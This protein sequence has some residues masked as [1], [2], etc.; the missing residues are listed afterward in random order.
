[1]YNRLT[2]MGPTDT[3]GYALNCMKVSV[4][5]ECCFRVLDSDWK[6][7]VLKKN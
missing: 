7:T 1:M 3:I 2:G 4:V 6:T 5:V